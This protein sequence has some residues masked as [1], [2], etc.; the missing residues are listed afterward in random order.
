MKCT[1]LVESRGGVAIS[2][3]YKS[4]ATIK[5]SNP[6]LPHMIGWYGRKGETLN[7][8]KRSIKTTKEG[9]YVE[10]LYMHV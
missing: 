10:V 2:V 9:E 5:Q 6:S 7:H 4:R 3:H 8:R 1:V